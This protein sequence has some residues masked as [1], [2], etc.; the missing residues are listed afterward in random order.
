[1]K[2]MWAS[3]PVLG[4]FVVHGLSGSK[5]PFQPEEC[6]QKHQPLPVGLVVPL[7]TRPPCGAEVQERVLVGL[8]AASTEAGVSGIRSLRKLAI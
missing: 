1:M 6:T 7:A 4:C 2:T 5:A 3:K 8:P